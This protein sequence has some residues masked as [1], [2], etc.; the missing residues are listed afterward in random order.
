MPARQGVDDVAYISSAVSELARRYKIDPTR[1]YALGHSNGA[2]MVQRMIC[3]THV[4]S[5]GVAIS[6]PLNLEVERCAGAQGRRVLAIHGADDR[7]VPLA[8]GV[9][10]A[11]LSRLAYRSE[12]QSSQTMIGS[13]AVY[14]LQV[15]PGVDHALPHIAEAIHASDGVTLAAKTAAFFGLTRR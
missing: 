7:N 2:M 13:G 11:G 5:A 1:V 8:G 9:G 6:G 12:A 10:P 14:T 4:L 3:E 15:L